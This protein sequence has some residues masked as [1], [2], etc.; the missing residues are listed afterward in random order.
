MR[1]ITRKNYRRNGLNPNAEEWKPSRPN[2]HNRAIPSN[3][4]LRNVRTHLKYP[5]ANAV[6]IDCEMVGIGRNGIASALAHVAIVDF[7]GHEIYNKYVIPKGGINSIT[8]YR[9][10]YSGITK[11]ILNRLSKEEHTFNTIKDEVHSILQN[12]IIVGH[13]LIND[14]KV[15]DYDPDA[16][17]NIVWD[18]TIIPKYQRKNNYN[19]KT[20]RARKLRNISLEFTGN[21][22]QNYKN[23]KG[24]GHSPLEDARASMNL[25]RIEYL[26]PKIKYNNMSK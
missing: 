13:G 6:A 20:F 9:T 26:H 5:I 21:K 12:R 15:L 2:S 19:N 18:T 17:N 14:F 11:N 23:I 7:E 1:N 25:F 8:N 22:I 24:D 16:N 10:H 4:E 3:Y